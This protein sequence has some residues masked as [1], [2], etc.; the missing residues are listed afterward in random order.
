MGE[1]ERERKEGGKI[2]KRGTTK[3]H[4]TQHNTHTDIYVYIYI[5]ISEGASPLRLH[6]ANELNAVILAGGHPTNFFHTFNASER[7][8]HHLFTVFLL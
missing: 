5:Y 8:L 2:T 7:N 4:T 1:R 3:K 6:L